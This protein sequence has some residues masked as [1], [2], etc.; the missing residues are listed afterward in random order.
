MTQQKKFAIPGD[1]IVRL[2][3]DQGY[4]FATDRITVDGCRVGYMY[5]EE[6]DEEMDSG[7][8]FFAGDESQEY[9]DDGKNVDLY[10]VN[11]IV[12]YDPEIIP[13]LNAPIGAAYERD[14]EDGRFRNAEMPE[15]LD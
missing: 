5:R 10:S 3:P 7:W 6:P 11:T 4:C 8:R 2:V 1:K 9:V 12:N 14:E 15:P 13:F